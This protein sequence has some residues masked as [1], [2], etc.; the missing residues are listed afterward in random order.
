MND[1][2]SIP[3]KSSKDNQCKITCKNC[4][5]YDRKNDYCA[6]RD[7]ENCTKQINVNFSQCDSYLTRDSLI[8]F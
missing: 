4:Q 6:E 3:K 1:K 5:F 2:K 7:I 8:Y